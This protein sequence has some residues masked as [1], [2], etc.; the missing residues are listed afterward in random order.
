MQEAVL[1]EKMENDAVVCRL[2]RH[3]CVIEPG[4]TGICA[5]RRN[6]GGTLYSLVYDRVAATAVDPIEKKPLFHFYPGSQAYSIATMGCNFSCRHCQNCTLSKT[7]ADTG[8]IEG[9]EVTPEEIVQK[10]VTGGCRSISY[11][12]TEPTVFAELALETA[13]LAHDAGLANSFVTNGY[14]STRMVG[15]M[16]GLIDAANVDLKSFSRD[17]YKKVCG[18]VL[19]KVLATIVLLHEA[20]LWLE[21]TTLV[22]PTMNDSEAELREIARFIAG[23]NPNIPWHVSRFHPSYKMF[24]LP[25]TPSGILFRARQIGLEAGLRYVY[26]GNIPGKG[27]EDTVCHGC[28]TTLIRRTGYRLHSV[29]LKNG[30]CTECGAAMAG[31]F[32]SNS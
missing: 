17:F 28:G 6:K 19:E 3:N 5:V 30:I 1:Y 16:R 27:G 20:G 14:Q 24:D 22:I 29:K 31:R 18:A 26:T 4:K 8:L 13:A 21:I 9:Q 2:C 15:E 11:T 10:A 25:P 12:Y 23:V 7:P 32:D